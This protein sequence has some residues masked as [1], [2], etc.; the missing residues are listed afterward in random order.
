[1][2]AAAMEPSRRERILDRTRGIIRRNLPLLEEWAGSHPDTFDYV[3]PAAGAIAYVG[4]DLPVGSTELVDR[5]RVEQ[6][7]LVV[8]GE[9]FGLGKYLRIGFGSDPEHLVKGLERISE[10]LRRL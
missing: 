9:Q 7:A 10:T 3:K 4:Y 2:A 6:S 1:M 8:P 5:I